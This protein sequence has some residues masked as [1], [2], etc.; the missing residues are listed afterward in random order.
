L[1]C[2]I[3]T[4]TLTLTQVG[5]VLRY[6]NIKFNN[7]AIDLRL[8]VMTILTK[9]L[10]EEF[11]RETVLGTLVEVWDADGV[12]DSLFGGGVVVVR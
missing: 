3:I 9:K 7:L 2:Y 1:E 10:P 8:P 11:L 5:N 12:M 4:L 6:A